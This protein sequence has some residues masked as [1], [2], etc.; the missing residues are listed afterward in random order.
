MDFKKH[1]KTD[2]KPVDELTE[3]EAEKEIAALRD[4]IG[5]HDYLYYVK[6]KPEISDATYDKLFKRLQELEETFPRFKSEDSPTVRVGREPV[7]QLKKVRHTAP[8]LSLQAVLEEK[9]VKSFDQSLRRHSGDGPVRY[10]LEPKFDGLSVEVVYEEGRFKYGA[11]RGDGER[12][13]DISHNLKTVGAIPLRL[14]ASDAVPALLAVRGEI[15]MPRQGFIKLNRERT[16]RDEEAF[17]NPRNAAAGIIRQL[18]PK[19]A[20]G[21]P[22]DVFFYEILRIEQERQKPRTH[23][24]ALRLLADSGL[25][26]SPLNGSADSLKGISAYHEKLAAQR[27]DLAYEIDGIVIKAEDYELRERLGVRERNPR[28]ALAW[29]FEPKQ[30]IT[31]LEDIAVQVGRTGMLTPVALLRPVDVGGVTVSR[32]TLHNEDEVHRKDLRLGDKVRIARAGD[33]IPEVIERIKQPGQPRGRPF[34]M[35]DRCPVCGTKLIKEGAYYFCPSNLSC[36]AQLI[37]HITHYASRNAMD[38]GHLGEKTARQLVDRGMVENL[39][40]LYALSKEN[41]KTLEGFAE[42]SAGQ[43]HEAIQQSRHARLDRF[44]YGLGIRQ[45]GWHVARIAAQE[46]RS[47]SA[48]RRADVDDLRKVEE[49][50]DETAASLVRFFSNDRNR[51]ILDRMLK[52]GLAIEDMPKRRG[53]LPLKGKTFV[54]TGSLEHYTR[55]EATAELERLG[56]HVTGNVSVNTDFI[57]VGA[58]PGSKLEAA[59]EHDIKQLDERDFEKLIGK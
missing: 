40:D 10:A 3:E 51:A 21:K 50:G 9:D 24:E 35:P 29:K 56:A 45:V 18:D 36:P 12:G 7:S 26:T 11:T 42:K 55:D 32:A 5:Y 37:G 59:R 19:K 46:F 33:V 22:L 20:A 13:E 15:F 39:A 52:L 48:L 57:V 44:L 58:N 23:G 30:E 47:L 2:F 43:L 25:K 8:L 54:L 38:I 49:I 28:W 14:R 27:D 31:T 4:G 1:P 17:A 6:N 53:G 34:S 41:L 16:E